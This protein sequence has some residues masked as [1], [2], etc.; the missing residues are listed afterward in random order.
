[1]GFLIDCPNCGR[2]DVYEFKFGGERKE[3][4]GSDAGLKDWRHYVHFN[5]NR[6]GRHEEWWY[7]HG[8]DEWLLVDR[9]TTTNQ[10]FGSKRLIDLGGGS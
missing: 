3:T 7:H 2:R 8:C 4:P 1:M 5:K 10:V 9:D 6:A